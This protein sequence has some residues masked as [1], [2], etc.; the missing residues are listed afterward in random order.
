MQ[1]KSR[2]LTIR[3]EFNI[4]KW[5]E[6]EAT[7]FDNFTVAGSSD[8]SARSSVKLPIKSSNEKL[9]ATSRD[10]S[11]ELLADEE[12]ISLLWILEICPALASISPPERTRKVFRIQGMIPEGHRDGNFGLYRGKENMESA[13]LRWGSSGT[14]V[15]LPSRNRRHK[16]ARNKGARPPVLRNAL[17]GN[18]TKERKK[19][20][21]SS[22]RM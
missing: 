20:R 7:K 5:R 10:E 6:Q 21:V 22:A 8:I 12:I 13:F 14:R 9:A 16:G 11:V 18:I 19:N 17:N 4:E 15:G 3:F 1:T 2:R